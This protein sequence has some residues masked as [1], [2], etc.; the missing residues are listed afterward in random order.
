MGTLLDLRA[1]GPPE[2]SET[3]DLRRSFYLAV[4]IEYWAYISGPPTSGKFSHLPRSLGPPTPGGR[5]SKCPSMVSMQQI[6]LYS[7]RMGEGRKTTTNNELKRH[8]T[9]KWLTWLPWVNLTKVYQFLICNTWIRI[10]ILVLVEFL[11][12]NQ[13][14]NQFYLI[15]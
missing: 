4:N 10:Q 12:Q 5:S 3:S 8:S 15:W 1:S 9:S 11:N 6:F 2:K 14:S 13:K 7:V